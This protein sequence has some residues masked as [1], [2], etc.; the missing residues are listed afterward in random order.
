MNYITPLKMH[1]YEYTRIITELADQIYN[2]NNPRIETTS[3]FPIDIAIETVKQNKLD[4][5]YVI[6]ELPNN[7]EESIPINLLLNKDSAIIDYRSKFT[8]EML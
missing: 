4:N 8:E 1:D 7:T 5:L 2:N 6:R 3:T